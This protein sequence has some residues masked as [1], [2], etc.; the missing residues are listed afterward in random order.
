MVTGCFP[1]DYEAYPSQS[2]SRGSTDGIRS[3]DEIGLPLIQPEP[4]PR[5]FRILEAIPK[6]ISGRTSYHQDSSSF[7]LLTTAH[8]RTFQRSRV[9][10][11]THFHM[12]FNLAMASSL[13]FGSIAH[14]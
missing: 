1:L 6:Y 4:Y 9:R 14:D 5:L 2:D 11:S 10:S 13:G 8:P 7:S 3:L 12:C